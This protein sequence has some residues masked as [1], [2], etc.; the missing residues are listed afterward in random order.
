[1]P[2]FVFLWTD[3]VLW[4]VVLGVAVYAW[5]VR[6]NRHALATWRHVTHDA[7]AMAAAVVL[8]VF[9][10][11]ALLDSIHFRPR[12]PP[13]PGAAADAPPAYATRTVS[14][15]DTL[16]GARGRG[17]REDVLGAARVVVVPARDAGGERQ[18]RCATS[19]AWR[20]AART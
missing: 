17:A 1:M 18:S 19:R 3:F 6:G 11:I 15:L 8:G 20:T 12:L 14:V 2:K 5:R 16:L 7:P 10:A 9:I 4:L 13:S